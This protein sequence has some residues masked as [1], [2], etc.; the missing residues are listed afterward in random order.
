MKNAIIVGASSGIGAAL[1]S[2]LAADGYN[3]FLI[4]RRI[5][6]LQQLQI[7]LGDRVQFQQADITHSVQIMDTLREAFHKMGHVDLVVQ[8]AGFGEINANLDWP[9]ELATIEVNVLG[10]TAVVNTAMQGFLRQ[11]S[12]HLVNISSMAAL[13]GSAEAPAYNAS[14]S[15]Q[16]NYLEG[17][18]LK[19]RKSRLP[20][21]IT[22]IQPGFV[23]TAMA[24]GDGL[25]WIASPQKAASQI[26]WAIQKQR[27]HA[28]VSRRWR[29]IAWFLKYAPSRLLCRLG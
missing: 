20:I 26:Y 10:F 1:A 4:A 7:E 17:L 9:L 23:D 24:K 5:D 8:C 18:L 6:R 3:L 15:F 16:S 14:K 22:D 27:G 29:L 2:V 25:F 12:G 13:R 28:Y 19:V 21:V 11:S